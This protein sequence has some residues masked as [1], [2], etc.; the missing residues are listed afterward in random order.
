VEAHRDGRSY[1]IVFGNQA[2]VDS[3]PGVL[4]GSS[5]LGTF[6]REEAVA[7]ESIDF[8]ASGHPLVEGLLAEIDDGRI[9]RTAILHVEANGESGF[10]LLALYRTE[11][12]FTA[13]CLDIAG[14]SRPD[15][16]ALLT[17]RPLRS[18]RVKTDALIAQPGWAEGIRMMAEKLT[19]RDRPAAV[20]AV[21][22]GR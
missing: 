18:R 8:Y 9:G 3:L 10:G 1:S 2:R 6:D 22:V 11:R 21:V 5:F 20:A 13:E 17:A 19:R 14:V 12:G 16:A 15:W 7:D 4:G